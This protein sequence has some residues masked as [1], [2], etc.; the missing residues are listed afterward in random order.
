MLT[1]PRNTW[2]ILLYPFSLVYGFIIYIRNLLF[3][4]Q[5]IPSEEFD[6]PVISV[7]NITVGGTGKTPHVEYLISLLKDKFRVST[8]SRG[9][10]RKT[11][12]FIL[13]DQHSTIDEIGD[14]PRQ[15]KS[16]FPD[17]HVAV[18][19]RRANGIKRLMKEIPDLDVVLLDDAYQHRHVKPGLSILLI[20]YNRPLSE[21]LLL[22]AGMLREQSF[23]KRRAHI[24]L[25]TKCPDRIKP[26]E[27][28]LIIKDLRLYPFQHLYFTKLQGK[29]PVPVFP[30]TEPVLSR[31]EIKTI[32]PNVLM[33]SGIAN[34]R[35]FKKYIRNYSTKITELIFPDHYAFKNSDILNIMNTF[36]D[37]AGENKI[38]LTTEKDAM[39][40]QQFPGIDPDVKS[41]MYY[42]PIII[43]FLNEDTENFNNHILNYVRNNKRNSILH[44]K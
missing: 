28:R 25:I 9:Y 38:I 27:R 39:R 33:I 11:R 30:E 24:I 23:E 7:G 37:M 10:K 35:S 13:A 16:K 29:D 18:G 43:D 32:K 34:P 42:I 40:F 15:I 3:D 14:E 44:K 41:K 31:Q 4:Y 12:H 19:R 21:D 17:V 6:M 1:S 36:R 2:R 20:D 22:P 26:I 5:L 8:L